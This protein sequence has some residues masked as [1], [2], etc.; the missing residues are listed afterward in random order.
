MNLQLQKYNL[1]YAWDK[2]D[3][4]KSDMHLIYTWNEIDIEWYRTGINLKPNW[5]DWK[6]DKPSI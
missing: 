6:F 4:E 3:T 2:T 1:V 5:M